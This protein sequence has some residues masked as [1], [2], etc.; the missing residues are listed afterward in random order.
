[1]IIG[2]FKVIL[3]L[4]W[5]SLLLILSILIF[6]LN[7]QKNAQ[8]EVISCSKILS[9][10]DELRAIAKDLA[11]F[12]LSFSTNQS[13]N[14]DPTYQILAVEKFKTDLEQLFAFGDK[15]RDIYVEEKNNFINENRKKV[16]AKQKEAK[17]RKDSIET[18]AIKLKESIE[19][20]AMKL[21]SAEIKF[22]V[23][24]SS[25]ISA[26]LVSNDNRYFVTASENKIIKRS[27][28]DKSLI[29]ESEIVD[30]VRKLYLSTS[31]KSLV[32][33]LRNNKVGIF[34]FSK[35]TLIGDW[36]E[37]PS[38]G[39]IMLSSK[40]K[41]L[42][43]TTQSGD[44]AELI[45]LDTGESLQAF[46]FPASIN[47]VYLSATGEQLIVVLRN[48]DIKIIDI[49]SRKELFTTKNIRDTGIIGII[50]AILSPDGNYLIITQGRSTYQ[51]KVLDLRNG[52]TI[53]EKSFATHFPELTISKSREGS[54][55][56][57]MG[58]RS[59][60][61]IEVV[62]LDNPHRETTI[63]S[64]FEKIFFNAYANTSVNADV[65]AAIY[66]LPN[67]WFTGHLGVY[68]IENGKEVYH[69]EA[70]G[71]KIKK[72]SLS[73]NGRYLALAYHDGTLEIHDLVTKTLIFTTQHKK[74][75]GAIEFSKD[76]QYLLSGSEDGEVKLILQYSVS[77]P[78]IWWT[79]PQ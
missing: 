44:R 77:M 37:F 71:K 38:I 9:S 51:V 6:V 24:H 15:Y 2:K 23:P 28:L 67:F 45:D 53:F 26:V 49:Q 61:R 3:N 47:T 39:K 56:L 59:R 31:D 40:L 55:Y 5:R 10:E 14:S 52:K 19:T 54:Q 36:F 42:I 22:S 64:N 16:F 29:Y 58:D 79:P 21:T 32:A 70:R 13:F 33:E 73:P 35:G 48:G 34:D 57:I 11:I 17:E 62:E 65:V 66:N 46:E 43:V 20:E 63:N 78:G 60:L 8:A 4:F 27:T 68:S 41:T 1:M 74:E 75:I 18:D 25:R 12:E 7:I 69:Y 30:H 50:D 76:S 72:D